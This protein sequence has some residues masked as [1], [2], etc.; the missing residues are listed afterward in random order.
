MKYLKHPG[1]IQL[2]CIIPSGR[3]IYLVLEYGGFDLA[4]HFDV[5]KITMGESEIKVLMKELLKTIVYMHQCNVVHRDL[6]MSNI[7]IDQHFCVKLCDFGLSRI[8]E[9]TMT[10]GVATLWYRAPE[11]LFDENSYT[12]SIDIW[13]LG[14]I[15]GELLNGGKPILPGKSILSQLTLI[16]SLIGSPNTQI[17]PDYSKYSSMFELPENTHNTL[18]LKFSKYSPESIDFLNTLLIWDPAERLSAA[19]ALLTPY[20]MS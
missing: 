4:Y 18:N 12:A 17:W 5:L 8:V 7:L 15:F 1:I 20:I 3:G 19:E 6:K 14:C 2:L 9:Q 11:L 13:S 16:C 10:S